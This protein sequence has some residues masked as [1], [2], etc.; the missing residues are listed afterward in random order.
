MRTSHCPAR[1]ASP[2]LTDKDSIKPATGA[3]T[4]CSWLTGI[5]T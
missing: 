4:T 2:A 3:A 1:T 5:T